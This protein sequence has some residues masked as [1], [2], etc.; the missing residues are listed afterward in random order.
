MGLGSNEVE[1][2][3][4]TAGLRYEN[5]LSHSEE[6]FRLFSLTVTVPTLGNRSSTRP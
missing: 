3:G 4:D 6:S 1:I 2:R 5:G